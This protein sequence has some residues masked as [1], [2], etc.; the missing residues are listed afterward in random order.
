MRRGGFTLLEV[1]IAVAIA[2][3]VIAG[4]FKL[5]ALS[6]YTLREVNAERELVNEAQKLHLEYM[7]NEDMPDGG[8]KNG[9]KWKVTTDSVP[10]VKELELTF[11]KLTVTYKG[12][13]M[14]LYLPE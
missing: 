1:L 8:E 4:G 2:G 5:I 11:R 10:V 14:V 9:V 7:T 13:E 6:L 3:S 12:R